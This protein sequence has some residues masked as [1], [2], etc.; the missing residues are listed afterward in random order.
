MKTNTLRLECSGM[1]SAHCNLLCLPG[2]V[3]TKFH[4]VGQTSLKLLTSGDL[5][6]LASPSAGLICVSHYIQPLFT[7]SWFVTWAVQQWL[8]VPHSHLSLLRNWDYRCITL[9]PEMKSMLSRLV[10]NYWLQAILPP[11]TPKVLRLQEVTLLPRLE[12]SGAISAHCSLELLGSSDP[13]ASA[14]QVA[15]MTGT[16]HHAYLIFVFLVLTEF[17]NVDQT[18]LEFLTLNGISLMLHRLECNGAISAHNLHLP[19]SNDSPA[20]ASCGA[21]ITG[22]SYRTQIIL[23]L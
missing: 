13:P 7:R 6:A 19:G 10:S 11:Q 2:P 8:T 9:C 12:C 14:S 22:M 1:T 5:P 15:G 16:H 17:H 18:S 4:H 20:S 21:G 23:Y 3:E